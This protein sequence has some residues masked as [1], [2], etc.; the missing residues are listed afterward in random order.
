MDIGYNLTQLTGG[1]FNAQTELEEQVKKAFN[2]GLNIFLGLSDQDPLTKNNEYNVKGFDKDFE[3]SFQIIMGEIQENY[4]SML[5]GQFGA[6]YQQT[7]TGPN[8]KK[9]TTEIMPFIMRNIQ[10][11]GYGPDENDKSFD[12]LGWFR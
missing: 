1:Q 11:L 7:M 12:W 2:D 6:D 10:A 4:Y 5:A 3:V 8:L 9:A